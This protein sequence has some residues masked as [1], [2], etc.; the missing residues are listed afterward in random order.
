MRTIRWLS[1]LVAL[2]VAPVASAS[3]H[4]M[5]IEQVIGGVEGD[6]TQ[7]AIQL[8]T[9]AG[10]QNIVSQARLRA[11][12]AV[13]GSPVLLVDMGSN[14]PMSGAGVRILIAT[15][16]FAAAQGVVPDFIM[17]SPIPVSYLAAG[18][19]TFE[20]DTGTILWSLAWGGAGYTGSNIG[21]TDNDANG[22][23]GPPFADPLPSAGVEA[24]LFPGSVSAQ[25][26][27]NLAD[28]QITEGPALF[29]NN[30]GES[31]I[32]FGN[33]A[34]AIFSDGFEDP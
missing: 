28:Y 15:P 30:A 25:S 27:T 9:R 32:V 17:T 20:Q 23:F 10:G 26:T 12:D 31:E 7:Q 8:R 4:F 11:F 16:E 1:V 6:T 29:T 3:F 34:S 13:G 33:D 22:D 21:D 18:R 14:V 5:Q 2:G 24:L 19:I